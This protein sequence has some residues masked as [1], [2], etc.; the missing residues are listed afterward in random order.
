MGAS[1]SVIFP[2][3]ITS[4]WAE[5]GGGLGCRLSWEQEMYEMGST[6]HFSVPPFPAPH[7]LPFA[8]LHQDQFTRSRRRSPESARYLIHPPADAGNH[9][10][11]SQLLLEIAGRPYHRQI[12]PGPLG[13]YF[14]PC[15]SLKTAHASSRGMVFVSEGD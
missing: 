9:A 10:S 5:A 3:A 13:C 4:C 2:R 1:F 6:N 12:E 15:V 8:Q 7:R 11:N 14:S